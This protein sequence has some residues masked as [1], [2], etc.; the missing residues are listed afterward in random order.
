MTGELKAVD[1]NTLTGFGMT[2]KQVAPYV[3]RSTNEYNIFLHFTMN[4]GQVEKVSMMTSDFLP[5]A[6]NMKWFT[7]F[8]TIA[9]I[10]CVI[11]IVVSIIVFIIN[12]I[13]NRKKTV[14]R[15]QLWKFNITL[16]LAGVAAI[17]NF[18]LLAYR[19]LNYASYAS[20]K[21]HF[22]INYIYIAV[23]GVCIIM[24]LKL[25]GKTTSTKMQKISYILSTIT[26]VL[27]IVLIIGWELYK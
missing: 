27:L 13:R 12:S 11:Y 19:A 17:I 1:S 9:V 23:I 14:Q 6:N 18:A 3:F 10:F 7:V 25:W 8:S 26:A 2:F 22:W 5:L 4:S 20:L 24:I 21:L 16:N 15:T